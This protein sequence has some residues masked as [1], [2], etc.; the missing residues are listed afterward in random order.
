MRKINKLYKTITVAG[1]VL[2]LAGVIAVRG[3]HVYAEEGKLQDNR[4]ELRDQTFTLGRLRLEEG[5]EYD[6]LETIP[7][8]SLVDKALNLGGVESPLPEDYEGYVEVRGRIK[9]GGKVWLEITV[10]GEPAG[11]IT[12]NRN[13]VKP[14][15]RT[16]RVDLPETLDKRQSTNKVTPIFSNLTFMNGEEGELDE[17]TEYTILGV[18]DV[19]YYNKPVESFKI[20][21][22]EG[23]EGWVKLSDI[24]RQEDGEITSLEEG[25]DVLVGETIGDG[26]EDED[27][28]IKAGTVVYSQPT[29]L[30]YGEVVTSVVQEQDATVVGKVSDEEVK[31]TYYK[32]FTTDGREGYISVNDYE[33]IPEREITETEKVSLHVSLKAP[34]VLSSLPY[35]VVGARDIGIVDTEEELTAIEKV[36]VVE[37]Q[38][39]AQE[40]AQEEQYEVYYKLMET[41]TGKDRGYVLE[42]DLIIYE[43]GVDVRGSTE[44]EDSEGHIE[45]VGDINSQLEEVKTVRDTLSEDSIVESIQSSGNLQ[46][47]AVGQDSGN[48]K[49]YVVPNTATSQTTIN[50]IKKLAPYSKQVQEG[51]L[52]PSVMMAQAILESDSGRSGLARNDN[53]LFGIKG[54]YR[55]QSASYAT[56]EANGVQ[57]YGI[58]AGFRRYPNITEGIADY[59][60]L[61]NNSNYTRNG[62][63]NARSAFHSLM[64]LKDAGYATDPLYVPKVWNVIDMYDLTQFD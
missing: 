59:I 45:E 17:N 18:Y 15:T 46:G 32:V 43:D 50:F 49:E 40:D 41:R 34:K 39:D 22:E 38:E 54:A 55:G 60:T 10:N 21:T 14:L 9:S 23:L 25:H 28:K 6:Y 30:E 51:G 36:K 57:F 35:G 12:Q 56:Q 47:W 44:D 33:N 19:V 63:V 48:V 5:M 16:E 1:A 61:L 8:T 13:E 7:A 64:G 26:I 58:Q 11:Y 29:Y 27:I 53:N 37:V 2:T 42:T 3:E 4:V 20:E 24:V 52:Y 62:V 31:Q